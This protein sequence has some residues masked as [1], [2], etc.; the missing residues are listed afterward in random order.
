MSKIPNFPKASSPWFAVKTATEDSAD[1]YFYDVIGDSWVGSDAATVVKEIKALKSKKL[2]VHISS[3]G[4]SVFDGIAIYNALNSHPSEVTIYVDGLAASIASIIALA[5]KKVVIAENAM[6][7][8]HN[9]WTWT[10]GNA[11]ELRKQADTLDQIGETLITTYASRTGKDRDTIR[12]AM[13]EETW[14]SAKEA[15]DWGLATEI[16]SALPLAASVRQDVA[17]ALA[18]RKTPETVLAKDA[19]APSSP[20]SSETPRSLSLLKRKQ[21]LLEKTTR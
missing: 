1:L 21:A 6:F 4:G 16:V 5:G 20:P 10:A 11:E 3:P 12:K 17:A 9:P 8:I 13:E 14:F 18:F 19:P 15:K 2:N 7:M